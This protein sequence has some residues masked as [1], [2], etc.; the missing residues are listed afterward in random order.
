VV[1]ALVL[2][3]GG[4]IL[5]LAALVVR[6]GESHGPAE[7]AAVASEHEADEDATAG[8]TGDTVEHADTSEVTNGAESEQGEVGHDQPE[9]AQ[10]DRQ[11]DS[12]LGVDV[13]SLNLA[14]PWLTIVL[15]GLTI[16]LAAALATRRSVG[17]LV[18][19]VGLG[20]AGVAIGVHEATRAGEELGIFVPLPALAAVLYGGASSLAGLAII[21]A[22]TG[23]V[24]ADSP[25]AV[26]ATSPGDL[27]TGRSE[28][29]PDV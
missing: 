19:C 25:G 20:L 17:L 14:S 1:L 4:I 16:L 9:L 28:G 15:T 10:A 3:S 21:T 27:P 23:S 18:A 11:S 24:A 22:R 5:T 29:A 2:L 13:Q 8:T 26:F 7:A 12:V 6:P